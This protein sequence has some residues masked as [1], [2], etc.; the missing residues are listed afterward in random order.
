MISRMPWRVG[1]LCGVM[2]ASVMPAGAKTIPMRPMS[3]GAVDSTCSRAGGASFGTHNDDGSYGCDSGRGSV[4][5]AADGTCVGY[6]S[7]LMR[8]PAGSL[9]AVLG[10]RVNGPPTRIGPADHRITRRVEGP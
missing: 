7:D 4:V 9:D 1:V 2:L 8:M 3:R 6:V 10:A 5:C